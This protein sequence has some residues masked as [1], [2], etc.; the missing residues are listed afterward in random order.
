MDKPYILFKPD[1]KILW[2]CS[3]DSKNKYFIIAYVSKKYDDIRIITKETIERGLN[4]CCF[5]KKELLLNKWIEFDRKSK[6]LIKIV[7]N[8]KKQKMHYEHMYVTLS[9]YDKSKLYNKISNNERHKLYNKC[10]KKINVIVSVI[11]KAS[12]FS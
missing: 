10:K 6:Y 5:W 3:Y 9:R 7:R 8:I 11:Y 4:Y 1:E 12:L 2:I